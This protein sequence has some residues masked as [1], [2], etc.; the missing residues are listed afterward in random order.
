MVINVGYVYNYGIVYAFKHRGCIK[1]NNA[2]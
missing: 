2:I 1:H